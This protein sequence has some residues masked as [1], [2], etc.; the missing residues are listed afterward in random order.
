MK[1]LI[2]YASFHHKNTEKIAKAIG[3]V[4]GAE[5]VDFTEADKKKIMAADLVGFGS[6]IYYA[7]FHKGLLSFMKSLPGAGGQKAFVFSTAGIRQNIF[8]NRGHKSAKEILLKKNFQIIGEFDCL[9]YDTNGPL[10][11][12]GGINR[13]RP[14]D[15]D[16]KRAEDFA[17]S[18]CRS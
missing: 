4:L 10:K 17:K 11:H 7:K 14:N 5:T 13:G 6:G 16:I 3:A 12:I 2:V 8:L 18:L 15:E 1:S 9:G